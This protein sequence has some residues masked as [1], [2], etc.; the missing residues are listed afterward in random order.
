V[1]THITVLY[2]T[3]DAIFLKKGKERPDDVFFFFSSSY[4]SLSSSCALP[5]QKAKNNF[6]KSLFGVEGR[7]DEEKMA[8]HEMC[9]M[10]AL[11]SPFTST[12]FHFVF[13]PNTL[14]WTSIV[15]AS[16]GMTIFTYKFIVSSA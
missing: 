11:G 5:N 10:E 13:I 8:F 1:I 2:N 6:K 3:L 9:Y 4:Q 14:L 12:N 16:V 7:E 15:N